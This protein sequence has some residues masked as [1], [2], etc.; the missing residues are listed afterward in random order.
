MHKI[1][2]RVGEAAEM[3]PYMH[4]FKNNYQNNYKMSILPLVVVLGGSGDL[5]GSED[6]I[7]WDNENEL[8]VPN[9]RLQTEF[10]NAYKDAAICKIAKA[11]RRTIGRVRSK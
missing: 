6:L 7:A 8:I 4:T 1:S 5:V 10:V 11:R 3:S 9:M 2:R